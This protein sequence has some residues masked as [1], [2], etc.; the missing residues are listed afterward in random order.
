MKIKNWT[1]GGMNSQKRPHAYPA[2]DGQTR[3]VAISTPIVANIGQRIASG[4][5]LGV[6]TSGA[7]YGGA[8]QTKG[9]RPENQPSDNWQFSTSFARSQHRLNKTMEMEEG[10]RTLRQDR[11]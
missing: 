6:E 4:I 9:R 11:T 1:T 10:Q 2:I 7:G 8:S 5:T 3:P